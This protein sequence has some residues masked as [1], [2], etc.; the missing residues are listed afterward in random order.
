MASPSTRYRWLSWLF[1]TALLT[2]SPLF[3]AVPAV[4]SEEAHNFHRFAIHDLYLL[5]A[6]I[7]HI[8]ELLLLVGRERDSKSGAFR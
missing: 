2:L 6:S 1:A 7:G 5:I 4:A 8:N 3:R